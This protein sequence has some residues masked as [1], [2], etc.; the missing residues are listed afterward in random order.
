MYYLCFEKLFFPTFCFQIC[1]AQNNL[2][3]KATCEESTSTVITEPEFSGKFSPGTTPFIIK[4]SNDPHTQRI[5]NILRR[6]PSLLSY[7]DVTH[8][9]QNNDV[10][11]TDA[12]R[13]TVCGVD[14]VDDGFC[15][16]LSQ[17]VSVISAGGRRQ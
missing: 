1:K 11:S 4:Y 14:I 3:F 13:D 6:Q 8:T 7:N 10:T 16:L 15:V 12:S 9:P 17:R 5:E 2:V